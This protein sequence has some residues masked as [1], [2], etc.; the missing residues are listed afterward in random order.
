MGK[1]PTHEERA[2]DLEMSS[3]REKTLHQQEQILSSIKDTIVIIT[4]HMKTLYAN[5][6][7]KEIFGDRPEMFTEP[8]YRFFKNR[9]A[10]CENCP[11]LKTMR[12]EKPHKAVMKSY[13]RNNEEIWRFNTAFPFYDPHGKLIAGIEIVTDYTP[14]KRAETALRKSEERYRN[15]VEESFDGIFIQRG[16]NIIFVNKRLNEMLGYG[17]DELVGREHW[18]VYHA[19]FQELTRARARARMGGEKVMPRYEVK[20]QRKDGSWFF[21]EINARAITFPSGERS[22]VQVWVKDIDNRKRAEEALRESEK[23]Y[24]TVLEANPDPVVVYDV[25]GRVIYFN[26]AFTRVFGWSLE[27]QIGKKI[28]S[29]VPEKNW[30]ETRMMINKVTV[31]GESFTGLETRRYTKDGNIL[32]IGISGSCYRDRE[33]NIAASVINLRD[34]TGQKRLEVQLQQAQKMEAI[35][36]LASGVAHDFNNLLMAIQG[37][38][39]TML[40]NKGASDRDFEHLKGIE[41]HVSSAAELTRQLLG[42]AMG[43]RYEVKP[44]DLNELVEKQNRMFGRTRKE[45][46][47]NSKYQE[48]IWPVEI[49]RGQIEQVL[50]N[51]YVNAWQAMSGGG[52]LA[53]ETENVILDQNHVKPFDTE[54][55][56][57]VRIS[58]SDTGVGMDK[59]TL[60]RIFDP[61][62]T[63]KGM[64]RGSGLG[65]ASAYGIIK[66]HG[67]FIQAHSE[68]GHGSIFNIYLPASPKKVIEEEELT[69]DILKGSETV[70]LVDDEDMIIE[71][72]EQ[73][74]EHLGYRVLMAGSGKEAIKIY[75]EKSQ[76]ID[77]VILDM[78]MPEMGGG[79]TYDALKMLNSKVKVLLSSGYSIDGQAT[80]ILGRGCN[81]FIQKPFKV[82]AFS[83]KL[84]EIL[85]EM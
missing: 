15:L 81:G 7:A 1:K 75:Q 80:E 65:L 46:V 78:V 23:K 64:G 4:P 19:D 45:I 21:G 22:G 18:V 35:G 50:L 82:E 13:D 17:G 70:L 32:H 71:V 12:D 61:F 73:L 9:E 2:L 43:G 37:R 83:Q 16:Q 58:V 54:Q 38:T 33:G 62:F 57:Y 36:T 3:D 85:D 74:L 6:T 84:R 28:D 47:I 14:Q 60:E 27:E 10:A 79:E 40:M 76:H 41:D 39:S 67:G 52:E 11:V 8:C 77:M 20:L 56:Q 24:R 48:N 26:P 44:S 51:L 42:F 68:K 63:T 25:E 29:F 31:L 49:D 30:P 72:A 59:T 66:N 5:Q 55:G 69:G 53:L 34:I